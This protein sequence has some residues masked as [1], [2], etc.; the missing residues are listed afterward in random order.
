MHIDIKQDLI[1]QLQP[2]LQR[3]GIDTTLGLNYAFN[4]GAGG[5]E[6]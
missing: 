1:G 6:S 4:L 2:D 5:G 3:D